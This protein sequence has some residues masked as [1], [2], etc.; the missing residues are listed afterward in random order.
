MD[1]AGTFLAK[2]DKVF[3]V[4]GEGMKHA[5][6]WHRFLFFWRDFLNELTGIL[7]WLF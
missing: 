5:D 2:S 6:Y 3:V 1:M 4:L 7:F